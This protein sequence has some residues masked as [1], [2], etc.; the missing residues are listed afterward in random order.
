MGGTIELVPLVCLKCSNPIPAQLDEIAWVCAQC[1]QAMLLDSETGLQPLV[2]QYAAGIPAN[3][4]GKPYWA[5]DGQ[6][7]MQ[8]A[9]YGG[10]QERQSQ[11]FWGQ[12]RRFFVP[13]YNISL[14]ELLAQGM[15]LLRQPPAQQPGPP[16][17]FLPVV[18]PV[19]DVHATAEF[20]VMAV[21]AE[22]K[23]DLKEIRF[24][25]ELGAPTLWILP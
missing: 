22:R 1:G 18:L 13:A 17:G 3:T 2:V 6:V 10:N 20:I 23:D 14:Q 21:E 4:Q 15:A 24:D 12:P 19:A 5:A 8:R 11:E 7:T 9:T 25:L 16:T